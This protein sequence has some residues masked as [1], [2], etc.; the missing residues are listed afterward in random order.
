MLSLAGA[1]TGGC[2]PT[3][4]HTISTRTRIDGLAAV[5]AAGSRHSWRPR[6]STVSDLRTLAAAGNGSYTLATEHG[7]VS[8]LAGVNLGSTSPGHQPGELAITAEDY[9]RDFAAM[10]QLGIRVVRIYTIH[11][12]AFYAELRRFNL[13]HPDDPLYVMPGVYLPDMSFETQGDLYAQPVTEAFAQELRDA[14]SAVYGTLDLPH[15]PG[16]ASGSW[17]ADV[18]G[19]TAGWLI[20]VEWEPVAVRDTNDRNPGAPQVTGRFFTTTPEASPAERWLGWRMEETAAALAAHGDSAPI[21]FVNWPTTDPLAHPDEPYRTEDLVSLDANHI[22]A[23][24]AWPGGQFASYH[25]YSYFPDFQHYQQDINQFQ[26]RGRSDPYVGYL[27]LLKTHH[28]ARGMPVMVTEFGVPASIGS[29]RTAPL[30]RDQGGHT[31]Q[32]AMK[33]NAELLT[34]IREVGM[35]GAI[36]FLWSD[37]WF[38]ST[39]NTIKHQVPGDRRQLWH[40]P[41][42]LEEWFGLVATDPAGP[43]Q[44][45]RQHLTASGPVEQV[46]ASIDEGYLHL[47]LRFRSA[48]ALDGPVVLGLDPI[49]PLTGPPYPGT[50]DRNADLIWSLAP[51]ART[52]QVLVRQEVDPVGLD[53]DGLPAAYRPAPQS[54]WMPYQLVRRG[55]A[56]VPTTG[57]T[58]APAA[59]EVGAVGWGTWDPRAVNYDSTALWQAE[60]TTL[61]VRIPWAMA[62]LSDPSSHRALWPGAGDNTVP[63][64]GI[65]LTVTAPAAEGGEAPAALGMLTWQG[66]ETVRYRLR[67][68][69]G[70]ALVRD[71]FLAAEQAG[72]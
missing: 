65:G 68:K 57:V 10:R 18:S 44:Q 64:E 8:F 34:A 12:P 67:L 11:P 23:T 54:G 32:E 63:V 49:G 59:A 17:R 38:K 50:S 29:A 30:G 55:L 27:S 21:A 9:R 62:G 31:E 1:S 72:S 70:A 39:W 19:W 58:L 46:T 40:D 41:L 42:S 24:P 48:T 61:R 3:R 51:R 60:G 13:A 25:V 20:G 37:Q 43:I 53:A 45:P 26:Y 69:A 66:W 35:A 5:A 16:H 36:L 2:A 7:P 47:D 28:A 71:A 22:T 52:G 4:R 33:I 6:P 56:T 14:V 15:R